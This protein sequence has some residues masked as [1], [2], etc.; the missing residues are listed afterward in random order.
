M[1]QHVVVVLVSLP[2]PVCK[3]WRLAVQVVVLDCVE[4]PDIKGLRAVRK[5]ARA[6]RRWRRMSLI[7]II[8]LFLVDYVSTKMS[9]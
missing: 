9:W 5:N 2:Q 8:P 1:Y 4:T 6:G 3:A 7:I